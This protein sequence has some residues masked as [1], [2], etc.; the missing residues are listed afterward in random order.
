MISGIRRN[1]N[2]RRVWR[3]NDLNHLEELLSADDPSTPKIIALESVYSMDGDTA[4]LPGVIDLA[5]RYNALTYLDEVHAIGLYGEQGRGIADRE[6]VLDRIDVIQGTMAKAIGV[7]GGF[8]AGPD[9][10]AD[11]VRSF[12]PGFIFT[13]SMPPAVAAAC[14]ASIQIVRADDHARDLLQSRTAQLRHELD[15]RGIEI[16]SSS[17]THVLPVLIGDA[18][19]CRAAAAMLLD[20]YGI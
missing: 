11:A 13:T 18:R 3:H 16:M 6:G 9:W 17:T 1:K 5:H 15:V 12:A 14:R 10:L 2:G 19:D 4:D 7:I 20:E 8:I